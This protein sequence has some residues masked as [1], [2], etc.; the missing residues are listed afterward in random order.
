MATYLDRRSAVD[1]EQ[2]DA[3]A[4]RMTASLLGTMEMFTIY[5]G[6]RLGFYDVLQDGRAITAPELAERSRTEPRQTR[7]WLEQQA[8]FGIL[9]IDDASDAPDDRRFSLPAAHAEVLTDERSLFHLR[10]F[11]QFAVGMARPLDQLVESF[12]TGSGVPWSDYGADMREGQAAQNRPAF[13][14][15]LGPEWLGAVPD[16]DSRL[17]TDPPARVADFACGAGWST[18]AIASAYPKAHVDG[19]DLDGPSLDLARKNL[20]AETRDVAARVS[21][22]EADIADTAL[23]SSYD[24]V[25]ILEALHD[26]TKPVEALANIRRLLAPGGSVFIADE[27]T[28]DAFTAPASDTEKL[29]YGFSV[30][31]CLPAGLVD[32]GSAGTGTVFRA[33]TLERYARG[34]GFGTV[35]ILPIEHDSFRFYRLRP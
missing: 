3:F 27:R 35:D 20:G 6:H 31:C 24:L 22:R 34:A 7:E 17:R 11:A 18:I 14:H 13:E 25:T 5:V 21:F 2:R 16:I 30:L 23:A 33:A 4:G 28:E 9:D 19:I 15:L 26:L 10:P 12:R 1:P 29:F 32:E 8:A